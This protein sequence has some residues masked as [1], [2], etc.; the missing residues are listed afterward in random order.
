M[1]SKER[2]WLVRFV[3]GVYERFLCW[4][5]G[6]HLLEP[7]DTEGRTY[8]CLRCPYQLSLWKELKVEDEK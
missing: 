2:F 3:V 4:F 6:G 5:L 1:V 8:E 7:T